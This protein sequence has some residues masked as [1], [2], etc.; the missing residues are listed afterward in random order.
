MR[1]TTLPRHRPRHSSKLDSPRQSRWRGT[2][3]SLTSYVFVAFLADRNVWLHGVA[4]T[5]QSTGGA[6]IGEEVWFL[7]QTPWA[8]L[9]LV[10]PFENNWLNAPVGVNL[11]DNTTMPLLGV[12][13]APITFLFGPIATFNVLIVLGFSGSAM[14][15]FLM[16]RRFVAWWPAAFVAGLLYG[17]SPFVVGASLAHLFVM[18]SVVPPL[19]ILIIHRF[20]TL[21]DRSPWLYGLALGGCFVAQFY[22]STEIFASLVVMFVIAVVVGALFLFRHAPLDAREV[23][24]LGGVAAVV[25]LLGVG[26]GA[27]TALAGPQ[28]ING[29]AQQAATIA[30][31]S[32]DPAGLVVPTANQHF[33]F[34]EANRGDS[35]VAERDAQGQITFEAPLEN[36]T[37]VGIPLLA[38]LVAGMV[39]LR[40][41]RFA[42]YCAIMALAGLILSMGSHLH[43][44]GHETG[45][46]L[47]FIVLAHL[48][49][50]ESGVASRYIGFFWLFVALIFALI[51]DR[52]HGIPWLRGRVRSGGACILV[53][54]FALWPLVPAWPYAASAATV[55][56]WFTSTARSL[57]NGTTVVVYPSANPVDSSAMVWQAMSNM[58]FRMPGGY[59]VFASPPKGTASFI[60]APSTLEQAMTNCGVG[61]APGISVEETRQTLRR[62]NAKYVVVVTGSAGAAC[63]TNMFDRALSQHRD[64]GGVAV[65]SLRSAR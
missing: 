59:A 18:F 52:I 10:N 65:W 60:A 30:G 38:V 61:L 33:Q 34:G 22:I 15:F 51:L 16:A 20:V 25:V 41:N 28:H 2:G 5:L 56:S 44:D 32:S 9:H 62:L 27:W 55:P 6:D 63:A 47:P 48:P 17:F 14:T 8:V 53:A 4:H 64:V 35:Y 26:Y 7:A 37:Y 12:L 1:E 46:P 19:I 43:V 39:V 58:T 57:P 21:G 24:R 49:L 11:M 36:G 3:F 50:L 40:R 42:V 45:V 31:L 54:V 23:A 13:G 29:P